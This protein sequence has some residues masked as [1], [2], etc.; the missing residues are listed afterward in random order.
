IRADNAQHP[1]SLQRF[2]KNNLRDLYSALYNRDIR[3]AGKGEDLKRLQAASSGLP[4]C[5]SLAVCG[6]PL[7]TGE[8]AFG[9]TGI[10]FTG[11][12]YA[13]M[14]DNLFISCQILHYSA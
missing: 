11:I 14:P 7:R 9:K 3:I 4:V 1:S 2:G 5:P 8:E 13:S 6:Q 12:C 10:S